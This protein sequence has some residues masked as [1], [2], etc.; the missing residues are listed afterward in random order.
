MV[1]YVIVNTYKEFCI[2]VISLG[3]GFEP[4]ELWH[5]LPYVPK[6]FSTCIYLCPWV[7]SETKHDGKQHQSRKGHQL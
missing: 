7:D 5:V 1:L 3:G 4:L 2:V 6:P